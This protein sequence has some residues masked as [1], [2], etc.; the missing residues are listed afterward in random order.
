M[1]QFYR[2]V[3]LKIIG[4]NWKAKH[5]LN[6][7]TK[8]VVKI[9]EVWK[10]INGFEGYY[11]ISNYGRIRS[12]DR[13][14]IRSDGNP[15]PLKGR[16][17]KQN[18][19][20]SGRLQIMLTKNSVYKVYQV[21]RLVAEHFIPNPNNWPEVNH[22]DENPLNN[23]VDN[24]EWCTPSY[25]VNYGTRIKRQA[26][27]LYKKVIQYDLNMNF[28]KEYNLASFGLEKIEIED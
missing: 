22:K 5:I 4:E 25:N 17:L 13:L 19:K 28:V 2:N 10:D 8:G 11:Q 7:Y 26:E 24:L 27:K 21:H 15:L 9:K 1:A 23:H 6:T 12:L 20:K 18:L 16:I 14:I 3:V